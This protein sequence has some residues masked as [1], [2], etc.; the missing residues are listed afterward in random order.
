MN[1]DDELKD[2]TD[3]MVITKRFRSPNEFSIFIDEM[4]NRLSI[5]YMDAVINYCDEMD[6]EI[7]NIGFLINQKLREKIQVEAEVSN[8]M[9]PRGH[10]P[11]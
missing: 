10:L 2:L 7:D 4:V 5:T 6:I 11:I 1:D 3:A 9:K 8:L